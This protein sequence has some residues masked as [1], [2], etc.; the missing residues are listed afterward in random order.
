VFKAIS[1]I[2]NLPNVVPE[3]ERIEFLSECVSGAGTRFRET[4]RMLGKENVTEPEVTEYVEND[5]VRMVAGSHGTVWDSVFVV[6][7]GRCCAWGW[8]PERTSCCRRSLIP[9]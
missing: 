9:C 1:D 6:A 8:M 5:R 7:P 4:R 2:A 3:I